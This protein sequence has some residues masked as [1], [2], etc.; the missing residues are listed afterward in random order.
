MHEQAIRTRRDVLLGG[1]AFGAL[2]AVGG[3][4]LAQDKGK[5]F[6]KYSGAMPPV[7]FRQTS[8][9]V[10]MTGPW[11]EVRTVKLNQ[12]LAP[13][14]IESADKGGVLDFSGR[15]ILIRLG[16]EASGLTITSKG[17]AIGK[18][19]P[20]PWKGGTAKLISLI[21]GNKA[22]TR[23]AMQMRSAFVSSFAAAAA[24]GKAPAAKAFGA[25]FADVVED[26]G[27]AAVCTTRTVT[28][29][30][31]RRV[32]ETIDVI[33]TAEQQY[34]RCF[35]EAINN[36][37]GACGVV[38]YVFGTPA[39]ILCATGYCGAITFFDVLVNTFTVWH[40]VIEE[41]TR[42]VTECV[43]PLK[44]YLPNRWDLP[45]IELPRWEV[46][47]ALRQVVLTA[48]D[49]AAA[50]DIFRRNLG[51]SL[52]FLGPFARCMLE[53]EWKIATVPFFDLFDLPFGIEICM[54]AACARRLQAQ[55]MVGEGIQA[56]VGALSVIASCSPGAAAALAATGIA[57]IAPLVA[58][59][60]AV[61]PAVVTAA[62]AIACMIA[63]SLYFASVVAVQLSF[64][65][66]TN[67]GVLSDGRVCMTHPTLAVGL[68]IA[69]SNGTVP[70]GLIP[71][72][73]TG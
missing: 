40:D 4:L 23:S 72:V 59:L 67:P 19:K 20:T 60:A 13:Y 6:P 12:G 71:P 5:P 10:G 1:S 24:Q 70:A 45:Q 73:V 32:E 43:K 55:N 25:T 2:L 35:D 66:A 41:V 17:F 68:I 51:S 47:E 65:L 61:P 38:K 7:L 8:N 50:L 57:P 53:A 34:E 3:P 9:G 46:P 64:V 21:K 62:L 11:G 44:G 18:A 31:T 30:V 27:G 52:S 39:A 54:T 69:M 33:V 56:W 22:W 49:I 37:N 16:D 63:A 14:F 29:S 36:P 48:G 26:F 28:E 42:E 15:N 58:A